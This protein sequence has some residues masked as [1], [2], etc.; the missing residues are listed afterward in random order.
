MGRARAHRCGAGGGALELP[1]RGVPRAGAGPWP[2][3]SVQGG[4]AARPAPRALPPEGHGWHGA[5][6]GRARLGGLRGE[7]GGLGLLRHGGIVRLREGALR[8]LGHAGRPAP[9][10]RRPG[11][12]GRY[13]NR[14]A[15]NLVPPADRASRGP[16]RAA[17]GAALAGFTRYLRAIDYPLT[18]I[19]RTD[20]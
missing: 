5:H 12:G 13:G 3:A 11:R 16:A 4:A 18:V 15:W 1:P 14:R 17:S 7:R 20:S 6:G 19:R 8:P 10:A 9:R 2:R